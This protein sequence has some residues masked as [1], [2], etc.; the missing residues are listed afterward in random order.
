[1][2]KAL[3]AVHLP[4][5][6]GATLDLGAVLLVVGLLLVRQ[7]VSERRIGGE[8]QPP[9]LVIDL[10][11]RAKLTGAVHIGLDVDWLQPVGEA[12][13]FGS[14][15]VLLN[16][17]ARAGDGEQVEQG[18][19]VEAQHL[20]QSRWRSVGVLEIEPPIELLLREARGAIGQPVVHR[21]RRKHQHSGFN[22]FLDD[23]A[24]QAVVACLG[25]HPRCFLVAKVMRLVDYNEVVVTPIDVREVNVAG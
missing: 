13:S 10:S 9:D 14:A 19:V 23:L 24:H 16:V 22:A 20:D 12:A 2:D 15:V 21:R 4:E 17:F 8:I 25:A 18:E 11:N 5:E 1:M 7:H 6:A 3:L